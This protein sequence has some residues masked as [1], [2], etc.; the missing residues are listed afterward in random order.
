MEKVLCQ[1][2]G[3]EGNRLSYQPYPGLIGKKI[4]ESISK[5]TW[6][7]WLIQQTMLLNENRLNPMDKEARKFLEEKMIEFLKIEM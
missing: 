6:D 4:Q 5:E 2:S 7:L 3:K 1:K